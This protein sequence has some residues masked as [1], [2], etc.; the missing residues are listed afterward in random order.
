M[1]FYKINDNAKEGMK[2]LKKFAQKILEESDDLES[3]RK[4][5]QIY[6]GLYNEIF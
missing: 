5:L 3:K 1:N 6:E 4:A 2:N